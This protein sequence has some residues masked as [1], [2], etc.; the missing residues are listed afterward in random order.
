MSALKN[1]LRYVGFGAEVLSSFVIPGGLGYYLDVHLLSGKPG[2]GLV[3]GLLLGVIALVL[4]L[5]SIV[6]SINNGSKSINKKP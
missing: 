3:S 5:K 2:V 6:A 1:S 4:R